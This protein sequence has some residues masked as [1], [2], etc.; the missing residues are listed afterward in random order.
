MA[1]IDAI[2]GSCVALRH[3][4]AG[5]LEDSSFPQCYHLGSSQTH[6]CFPDASHADFE[7][8]LQAVR[9][10]LL[11]HYAITFVHVCFLQDHYIVALKCDVELIQ[12]AVKDIL[13]KVR[14]YLSHLLS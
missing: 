14:P 10:L 2:Y 13:H 8:L 3:L 7:F 11:R 1:F 4:A 12:L 6:D 9:L 5:I